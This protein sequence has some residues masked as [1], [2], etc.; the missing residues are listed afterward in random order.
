MRFA[1]GINFFETKLPYKILYPNYSNV[2]LYTKLDIFKPNSFN[3][4]IRNKF[5]IDI[6]KNIIDKLYQDNINM[7]F[8]KA[9]NMN[10]NET[11]NINKIL[12]KIKKDKVIHTVGVSVDDIDSSKLFIENTNIDLI[13]L[14][15]FNIFELKDYINIFNSA[16]KNNVDIIIE[17]K[18]NVNLFNNI[19]STIYSNYIICDNDHTIKK[20]NIM[21][22][23][24]KYN[25][26]YEAMLMQYPLHYRK[27]K[28]IV[29]DCKYSNNIISTI[30]NM[31]SNIPLHVWNKLDNI[32]L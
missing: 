31:N 20:R 11:Y 14:Q 29:V 5:N 24:I 22:I 23:L 2:C 8:I 4:I 32:L 12:E 19:P 3:I 28:S 26:S 10:N 30:D 27:V 9:Y 17:N 6:M 25:I 21:N 13:L 18:Y 15:K 1:N 7:L 16:Q